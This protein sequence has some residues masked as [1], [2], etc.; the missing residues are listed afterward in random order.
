MLKLCPCAHRTWSAP[1]RTSPPQTGQRR[2]AATA[3]SARCRSSAM[4]P[5]APVGLAPPGAG[6]GTQGERIA[7][8]Y[9]VPH[10]ASG[11]I[12]RDEVAQKTPLGER[13]RTYLDA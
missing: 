10:I 1:A 5:S 6:K 13:L 3:S 11:D 12:F 4:S 2:K 9:Q 8:R 7:A